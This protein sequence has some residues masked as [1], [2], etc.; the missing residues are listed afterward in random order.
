V[1]TFIGFPNIRDLNL[2]GNAISSV[3]SNAYKNMPK[4]QNLDLSNNKLTGQLPA[5]IFIK[6]IQLETLKLSNN[7]EMK[8]FPVTG[9]QGEFSEMYLLD[10]SRCG[11]T[12]LEEDDLKR[13]NRIERLYLSENEI[14]YIKP[15]VLSPKIIYLDLSGN[16]IAHLDQVSFPSGSSL[17]TLH[18][19]GNPI[20]KISP[21][22]F[23][24]IPRLT[25][26][27]LKSCELRQL[28]DSHEAEYQPLR[29]LRYLNLANNM[30]SNLSLEDFEYI[31]YV[32]TLVL[33]GNPLTCNNDL[34][35]LVKLLTENGVATSDATE[36]KHFEEMK[37]KGSV[38]TLDVEL[39]SGW[40]TFMNNMCEKKQSLIVPEP[41]S[42]DFNKKVINSKPISDESSNQVINTEPTPDHIK[43]E[44]T[45]ITTPRSGQDIHKDPVTHAKI[46]YMWPII[47]VSLLASSII[48]VLVILAALIVWCA[49]QKK[50][51][52]NTIVR[53]HS[54]CRTPRPRRG[55]TLYQQL[56]EDPLTP[57]TPVMMPKVP[58]RASEQQIYTFPDKDTNK[59][60]TTPIQPINRVSYLIS[61]FHHSNI[62]PE[63]V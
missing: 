10:A 27:N 63:S 5:D 60:T 51:H 41:K 55:S 39:E 6:N 48:L 53:R 3:N 40:T 43:E 8:T 24:N 26:L 30:I 42:H 46:N 57:T 54:I 62:V 21:A 49:R 34:K 35:K 13:M 29:A 25:R 45:F 7:P 12:H 17:K 59:T 4:L 19:S 14:Q 20:K 33:D 32:Q 23:I 37:V 36:K 31:K 50:G 47:I 18:L 61:P 56:R 16:K 9:F 15:G 28:W 58:E 38:E 11:L 52:R 2:S 44:I 22:Q 1:D